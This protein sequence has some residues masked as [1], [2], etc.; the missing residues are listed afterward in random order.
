MA[1]SVKS[2]KTSSLD[3]TKVDLIVFLWERHGIQYGLLVQF[4]QYQ[5]REGYARTIS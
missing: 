1:L 4:I 5:H 3:M 2:V